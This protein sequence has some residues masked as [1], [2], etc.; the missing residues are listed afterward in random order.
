MNMTLE[1]SNSAE[2]FSPSSGGTGLHLLSLWDVWVGWCVDFLQIFNMIVFWGFRYLV[3]ACRAL[4][5]VFYAILWLGALSCSS[6]M[7]YFAGFK[8][9]MNNSMILADAGFHL[10]N[11][12]VHRTICSVQFSLYASLTKAFS[13]L[14]SRRYSLR[15]AW[16]PG[17]RYAFCL[18]SCVLSGN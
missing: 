14:E 13:F 15:A 17:K 8:R 4:L 11:W 5:R 18:D 1:G 7:I 9:D 10:R 16:S 3:Y 12:L 2:T 6:L